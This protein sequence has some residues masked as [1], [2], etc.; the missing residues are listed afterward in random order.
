MQA[1]MQRR[2]P[3]ETRPTQAALEAL[4]AYRRQEEQATEALRR[5]A[6][7]RA[8]ASAPWWA[9][10]LHH[11][12]VE[13]LTGLLCPAANHVEAPSLACAHTVIYNV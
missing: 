1:V 2:D 3:A 13:G 8:A 10:W 11:R 6:A 7:A 9:P 5:L 12:C 4:F